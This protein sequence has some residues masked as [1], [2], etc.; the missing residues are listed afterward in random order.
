MVTLARRAGTHAGFTL[1]EMMATVAIIGTLAAIAV[2]AFGPLVAGQRARSASS[3]LYASLNRARSEAIKRNAEV[4]LRPASAGRWADGWTIV[5]ASE[6]RPVEVHGAVKGATLTGPTAVTYL[7][8]GRV[9]ATEAPS[10]E[11]S[12]AQLANRRCVQVDLSGRPYMKA[13]AC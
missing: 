3:E 13:S 2:P 6:T 5:N 9:K 8:N 10:F 7:P 11:L 1:P 12:F 4:T